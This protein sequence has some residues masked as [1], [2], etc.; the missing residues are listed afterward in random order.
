VARRD[1][2]IL[3]LIYFAVGCAALGVLFAFILVF[4]LQY[5]R[6]D[7]YKHLWLLLIPLVLSIAL[8]VLAIELYGKYRRKKRRS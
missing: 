4:A 7:I 3:E 5:F 6:I 1:R 8:N 2:F